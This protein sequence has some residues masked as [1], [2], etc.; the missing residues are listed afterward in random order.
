MAER[1][2]VYS[3]MNT[4]NQLY[5][6]LSMDNVPAR[7][8]DGC[9]CEN[10][11]VEAEIVVVHPHG[12]NEPG[13]GTCWKTI[14]AVIDQNPQV[15][16]FMLVTGGNRGYDANGIFR[17]IRMEYFGKKPNLVYINFDTVGEFVKNPS[18]YIQANRPR[19]EET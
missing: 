1:I 17:N 19:R 9:L 16:F 18:Q 6:E 14:D 4:L 10:P 8:V 13:G 11:L 15:D 12:E 7:D 5:F 3:T 2:A